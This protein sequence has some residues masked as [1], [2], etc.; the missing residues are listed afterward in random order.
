[1]S[2]AVVGL[3][4]EERIQ[5]LRDAKLKQTAEKRA[6][7]GHMDYDDWAIILPPVEMRETVKLIGASGAPITD[8]KIA[9]LDLESNHPSGGFF[10]AEMCGRNYR[11]LLEMHPVYIDPM[12]SLAGAYMV[13]FFSYRSPHWNPDLDLSQFAADVEKY[14]LKNGIGGVQHFCQDLSIGLEL[15]WGA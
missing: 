9:G 4:Y 5:K 13:N 14:H 2:V 15:G 10:G 7:I 12:S 11:K 1:M 8:V 6:V 3:T